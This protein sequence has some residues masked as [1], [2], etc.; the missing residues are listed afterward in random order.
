M[1]MEVLYGRRPKE[2]H[3]RVANRRDGGEGMI[4]MMK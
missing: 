4:E 1:S 3:A 2:V